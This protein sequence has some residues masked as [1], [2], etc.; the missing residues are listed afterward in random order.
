M[1][2]HVGVSLD[3]GTTVFGFNPDGTG[4]ALYQLMETL[5][6]G[7]AVPG[8][9]CDD[10]HVFSAARTRKL[11]VVSFDVV[12]P[13]PQFQAF[14]HNLDSQRRKSHYSYG[15]P[16][17]SGDCNC[18]TWLERMGLPLLTGRMNELVALGGIATDPTRRFGLCK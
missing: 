13:E 15:F 2:G 14:A 4:V 5:R 16:N 7:G 18:A 11:S 12:V 17:G 9:V 3:G 1:A 10:T 8:I 6:M